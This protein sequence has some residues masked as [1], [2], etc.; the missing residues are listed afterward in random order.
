MASMLFACS[1]ATLVAVVMVMYPAVPI[2]PRMMAMNPSATLII[3][4]AS[5]FVSLFFLCNLIIIFPVINVNE[6]APLIIK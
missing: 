5:A 4:G 2:V 6:T 3:V 1:A